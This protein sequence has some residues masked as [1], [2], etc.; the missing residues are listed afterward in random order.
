MNKHELIVKRNSRGTATRRRI[1]NHRR[2]DFD[3]LEVTVLVLLF[4]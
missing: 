2:D 4:C 3:Q 1:I